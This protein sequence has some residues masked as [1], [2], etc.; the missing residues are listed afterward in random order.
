MAGF[1]RA[2]E[3]SA[4]PLRQRVLAEITRIAADPKR[5]HHERYLAIYRRLQKRDR[6]L[7]RAFDDPRRSRMIAQLAAIQSF[8]LLE[9]DEL[10]GFSEG[11]QQTVRFLLDE[12]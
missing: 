1:S 10:A 5:S 12:S 3:A 8:R 6:E 4:G 11:T 2:A 7:A 9:P